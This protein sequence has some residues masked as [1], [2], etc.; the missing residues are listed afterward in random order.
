M[1][2]AVPSWVI[3]GTYGEN[4]RFLQKD[5]RIDTVELLFFLYDDE[6]RAQLDTEWPI[7]LEY[8]ERFRYTV[9]LPDALA[10]DHEELIERLLPVADHFVTHPGDPAKAD[11][12]AELIS[13]W[14]RQYSAQSARARSQSLSRAQSQVPAQSQAEPQDFL[15]ILENTQGNRLEA[16][17]ERLPQ[18]GLCMDTGHL[19]LAGMDP[20]D[21]YISNKELI[22]E[23]HLHGVD[24]EAAKSDGRLPDHRSISGR[25]P[26]FQRME[27]ELRSFKGIV[28]TEVFSWAEA[29]RSLRSLGERGLIVEGASHE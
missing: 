3:S 5:S 10:K 27:N 18:A 28:N 29:E 7:I 2:I 11:T 13:G 21:Y 26:W 25:E 17:R 23:I 1:R 4:L 14:S 22:Q 9:H 16:L 8:A 19:L 6:V 12:L 24:R 15:F 20:V